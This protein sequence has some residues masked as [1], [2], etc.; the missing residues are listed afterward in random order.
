MPRKT[1][2]L[3]IWDVDKRLR[4]HLTSRLDNFSNINLIFPSHPSQAEFKK[5]ALDANI[6]VGWRPT[7]DLLQAAKKLQLFINPGAGVQHLIKP[8][9]DL[10]RSREVIL[11]N[12]HGNS[13]FVA[14]HAIALLLALMNKI[15][16]HHNLMVEGQWR[17]RDAATKSTPLQNRRVGLLGYGA[18]NQKVHKLLSGFDLSF[19]ILRRAWN[20]QQIQ[21]LTQA[22][23]HTPESLHPFLEEIDILI[24]AVPL[25]TL[26]HH[27]IKT[28][29]LELLGSDGLLIN[30]ARGNII[31]EL[32]L[33]N[34]LK[35][36]VIAGAAI[37]VWYDYDPTPDKKGRKYP[38]SYPFHELPNV[39]LSPHRAASP[40]DDL[41]RWNEVIEN[42]QR[43]AKGK[44]RE[45]L[46]VVNLD[47]EY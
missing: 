25:T 36:K 37:D 32:S 20:N 8:F 40:L 39:I 22:K 27:L 44:E 15:I 41:N 9:V 10:N 7:Q 23:R 28:R 16:I 17:K 6:I 38:Y 46:N 2:V 26:T 34:A 11:T 29:E 3:F 13:P 1:T 30:V 45:L 43:F 35:S 24:I 33:F 21:L 5:L 47:R 14:Q 4:E 19:S 18:I 31:D 12:G 42:I